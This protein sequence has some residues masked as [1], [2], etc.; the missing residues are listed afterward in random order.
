METHYIK[1]F[2]NIQVFEISQECVWNKLGA[3]DEAFLFAFNDS[4]ELLAK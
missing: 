1:R 4:N 3:M 2:N